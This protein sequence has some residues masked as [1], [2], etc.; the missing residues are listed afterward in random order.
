MFVIDKA[1]V[2][3]A[4]IASVANLRAGCMRVALRNQRSLQRKVNQANRVCDEKNEHIGRDAS[5]WACSGQ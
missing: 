1:S 5:K 2:K 3:R 4:E